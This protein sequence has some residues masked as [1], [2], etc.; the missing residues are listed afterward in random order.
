MPRKRRALTA[1]FFNSLRAIVH[2]VAHSAER[3]A[4][5]DEVTLAQRAL[6]H[7]H[8]RHGAAAFLD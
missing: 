3:A 8:L 2:N 5:G 6:L 7:N 1:G 4:D